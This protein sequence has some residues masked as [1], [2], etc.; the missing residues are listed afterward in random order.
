[1][2]RV[3][4]VKWIRRCIDWKSKK[5]VLEFGRAFWRYAIKLLIFNGIKYDILTQVGKYSGENR[6]RVYS[7]FWSE[8]LRDKI[9]TDFGIVAAVFSRTKQWNYPSETNVTMHQLK[10][11]SLNGSWIKKKKNTLEYAW[12]AELGFP[13][14]LA[15]RDLEYFNF[16]QNSHALILP[17]RH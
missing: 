10:V 8:W 11:N 4:T 12:Y 5:I 16:G 15:V 9:H 2:F 17:R 3:G 1:M 7:Q 14:F 13:K 6:T